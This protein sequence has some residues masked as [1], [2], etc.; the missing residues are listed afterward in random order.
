EKPGRHDADD[1]K[2]MPRELDL[3]A[4]CLRGGSE[5]A[6]PQA[7]ADV[8]DRGAAAVVVGGGEQTPAHGLDFEGAEIVAAGKEP[9]NLVLAARGKVEF[10][11][12]L[13]EDR[14]QDRLVVA[15]HFPVGVRE[16]V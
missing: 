2:R 5:A 1:R 11:I 9:L 14:G 13:G 4:E 8:G 3:R 10:G 16:E 6:A 12:E 15:Y 7:L